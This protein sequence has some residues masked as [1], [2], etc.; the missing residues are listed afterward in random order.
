M[1]TSPVPQNVTP[2]PTVSVAPAKHKFCEVSTVTLFVG[3]S[4]KPFYVHRQPLCDASP[5]LQGS[6]RRKVSKRGSEKQRCTSE[7]DDEST[8]ELFVDW[9]YCQRYEMLPD[10]GDDED[11]EGDHVDERFLQPFRLFVFADKYDVCKLKRPRY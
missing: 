7:E 4:K 8:F 3:K 2:T 9:L 1:A 6:T 5:V 11:D 10:D